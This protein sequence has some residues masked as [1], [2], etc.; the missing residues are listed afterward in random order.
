MVP[1]LETMLA[2]AVAAGGVGPHEVVRDGTIDLELAVLET[3]DQGA[4]R[5]WNL[6]PEGPEA[7]RARGDAAAPPA[8]GNA[9]DPCDNL[10]EAEDRVRRPGV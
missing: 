10:E 2:R 9:R 3:D 4:V 7:S 6:G 1:S 5:V 8:F